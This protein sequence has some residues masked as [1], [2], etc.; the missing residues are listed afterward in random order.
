MELTEITTRPLAAR[1]LQTADVTG[2]REVRI[3]LVYGEPDIEAAAAALE[4]DLGAAER[5]AML[6]MLD[7]AIADVVRRGIR[8]ALGDRI[9]EDVGSLQTGHARTEDE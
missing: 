7:D 9:R 6:L 3:T 4:V 1:A 5:D 2:N 8:A